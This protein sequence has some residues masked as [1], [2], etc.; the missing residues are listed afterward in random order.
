M[1]ESIRVTSVDSNN[2]VD[3]L[4]LCWGHLKNW[5]RLEIAQQSKQWLER[6][7]ASFSPTTFIAYADETPA[8]MIEFVPQKVMRE[9]GLCPCRANPETSEVEN[10]YVLREE[11]EHCLFVSCLWVNKDYQGRGVGKALLNH[12]LRSDTFRNSG[13]V[14]VYAAVRDERWEKHMHWP[15]GPVEFWVRAGFGVLESLSAPAGFMLYRENSGLEDAGVPSG[16]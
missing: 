4:R 3:R 2:L 12:L 14:L 5:E 10:R 6:A 16:R 13:G 15:A 1:A 9:A 7:N 8:G 11:F